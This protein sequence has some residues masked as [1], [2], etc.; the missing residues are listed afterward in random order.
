MCDERY[1]YY[2]YPTN[3]NF[4]LSCCWP[5]PLRN[6]SLYCIIEV[7]T[8]NSKQNVKR[9]NNKIAVTIALCLLTILS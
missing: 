7:L 3:K 4:P 2:A 8:C 9:L 1:N 5:K 6:I